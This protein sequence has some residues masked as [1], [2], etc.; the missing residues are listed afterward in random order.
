MVQIAL[1]VVFPFLTAYAA[2][3]DLLTMTIPNRIS[4]GL[5]AGFLLFALTVGLSQAEWLAHGGAALAVLVATFALFA[6]G[7]M[8]GGDAKLASATALWLG[9]DGLPAYLLLAALAGGALTLGI[10]VARGQMLPAFALRLPFLLQL[11][12]PKTG[13][14]YGIALAAAALLALPE[15]GVW[16]R[17]FA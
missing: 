2:A 6:L 7:W 4:L 8:G 13:I 17:A 9:F 12:H 3:S 1:L 14:P 5:A 15:S 16:L 11:H 10:V